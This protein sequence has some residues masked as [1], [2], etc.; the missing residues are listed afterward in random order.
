MV[1]NSQDKT[2]AIFY[3][4]TN[5][6]GKT[7]LRAIYDDN[8][9]AIHIDPDQLA[10]KINPDDPSSANVAA[11]KAAIKLFEQAIDND[12][13]FTMESTLTGKSVMRRIELA[14]EKG[15]QTNLRYVGLNSAELNVE[16][17]HQRV[18][19]GGHSIDDDVVRRRYGESRDN[20]IKAALVSDH[21]EIWD[22]SNTELTKIATV[23][24]GIITICEG[25]VVPE[26]VNQVLDDIR[27]INKKPSPYG[28]QIEEL[29]KSNKILN[30]LSPK[31][32]NGKEFEP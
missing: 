19:K 18:S 2:I 1:K 6:S 24:N 22:N 15:F 31:V 4:G 10:R 32:G 5:G 26:W 17:V 9:I 11:A 14:A 13:S 7:T 23:K 29:Q 21:I 20:L 30:E 28:V 3:G 25:V 8:H 27:N 16:R 12:I